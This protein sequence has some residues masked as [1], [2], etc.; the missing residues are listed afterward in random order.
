MWLDI[1]HFWSR[2]A[3]TGAWKLSKLCFVNMAAQAGAAPMLGLEFNFHNSPQLIIYWPSRIFFLINIQE[4]WAK[5]SALGWL[6]VTAGS[7]A[8]SVEFTEDRFKCL[9]SFQPRQT[10]STP[11]STDWPLGRKTRPRR[12]GRSCCPSQVSVPETPQEEQA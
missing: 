9:I 5:T 2:R 6:S 7:L 3:F 1:Q 12:E 8:L 10:A 11:G 4:F